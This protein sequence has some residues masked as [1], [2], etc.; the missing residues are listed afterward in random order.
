M[1]KHPEN[2][3][4]IIRHLP[5][6]EY[7]IPAVVGHHEMWNG[8]GYPRR[9]AGEDIPLTARILCVAD[10]FDAMTTRRCYQQARG[11]EE[12]LSVIQNGAG[13]QFDPELAK[14]FVELVR[15]GRIEVQAARGE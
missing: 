9:L 14:L 3:V 8:R 13:E 5:S 2:A 11:L 7:V 1:K 6:M 4:S 12:A 15:Q 10:C